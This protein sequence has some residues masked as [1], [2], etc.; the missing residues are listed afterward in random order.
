MSSFLSSVEKTVSRYNMLSTGDTVII[1]LSGGAD[2]VSLLHALNSLKE[3]YSLDLKAAHMNHNLR[4][5]EALRDENF[6]RKICEEK[7]V[8]LFVKSVDINAVAEKEKISTE[9]AGRNERY[10][11]FGELSEKYGA[12]I[13]TLITPMIMSKQSC[14]TL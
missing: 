5:D 13:A 9:L 11:F 7:G 14:S 4:G 8:E 6:C 3:K 10:K 1:A 12:K 2:S